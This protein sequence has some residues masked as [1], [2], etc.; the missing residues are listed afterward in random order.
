MSTGLPVTVDMKSPISS[1]YVTPL[2]SVLTDLMNDGRN[3]QEAHSIIRNAFQIDNSV[4]LLN[5]DSVA[6]A[7]EGNQHSKQVLNAS[8]QV[9]VTLN[10]VSSMM[11]QSDEDV[12]ISNSDVAGRAIANEIL[13]SSKQA[14]SLT[15]NSKIE[16]VLSY[17]FN[18]SNI[19]MDDES[20]EAASFLIS[21]IIQ[22]LQLEADKDSDPSFYK[23]VAAENQMAS[24]SVVS[25]ALKMLQGKV[26]TPSEAIEQ[27][28]PDVTKV[29]TS[30]MVANNTFAPTVNQEFLFYNA[31]LKN[32]PFVDRLTASDADGDKEIEFEII[33]GNLDPDGDDQFLLG[34][35]KSSGDVFINDLMILN[36]YQDKTLHLKYGSRIR[37][38]CR[39]SA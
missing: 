20:I 23:K 39:A 1:E 10:L 37:I 25:P 35:D 27:A 15:E 4:D 16:N 3:S 5:F 17:A 30:L 8:T 34:I 22:T 24:M 36:F 7:A 11:E 12:E 31:S 19:S 14:F 6:Q 2:T 26:I 21:S 13:E 28:G 29:V 9:A 38:Y 32:T 33:S 18:E